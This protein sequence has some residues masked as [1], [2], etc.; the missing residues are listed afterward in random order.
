[1]R[2]VADYRN[3]QDRTARE[4]KTTIE[5]ALKS[6]ARD[7]LPSIDNLTHALNAV[8]SER[9]ATPSEQTYQDLKNLHEGV[10]L[11]ETVLLDAL[12]KHGLEKY[13][14]ALKA[15]KFDPNLHEAMFEAPKP[16]AEDG[17]V[18]HTQRVGYLLNDHVLR[19]AQVG[20][21]KNA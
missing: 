14:P 21:V 13:D 11:M 20:V 6:L 15:E 1:M 18:F 12:R 3:L 19:A 2:A 5:L 7:L 17:T 4:R 16:G 9:L 10:R 8:P